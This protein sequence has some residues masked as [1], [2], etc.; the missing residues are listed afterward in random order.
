MMIEEEEEFNLLEYKEDCGG[1]ITHITT[2]EEVLVSLN[3]LKGN[4]SITTMRFIGSYQGH[5]LQILV[6]TGSDWLKTCSPIELDY[7]EMTMTIQWLGKRVKRFAN[8]SHDECAIMG[9]LIKYKGI[10]AVGNNTKQ[11]SKLMMQQL[12]A[13]NCRKANTDKS[14]T[15][16]TFVMLEKVGKMACKLE[17]LERSLVHPIFHVFLLKKEIGEGK[18]MLQELPQL[19]D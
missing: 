3:A 17:L 8:K 4:A 10:V 19:S 5:Q 2:T 16:R 14:R 11:M 13:Q 7:E 1:Q 6:D 9:G 15:D 18:G 12:K